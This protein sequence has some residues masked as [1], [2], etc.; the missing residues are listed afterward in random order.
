MIEVREAN[1]FV[2]GPV[3]EQ[4]SAVS[5]ALPELGERYHLPFWGPGAQGDALSDEG[6]DCC[7]RGPIGPIGKLRDAHVTQNHRFAR[8]GTFFQR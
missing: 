4:L 5:P 3:S 1:F 2:S 7:T 8:H 6:I